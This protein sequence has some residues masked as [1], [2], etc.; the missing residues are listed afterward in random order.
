MTGLIASRKKDK[1]VKA[2][3]KDARGVFYSVGFPR[4]C[5]EEV[6]RGC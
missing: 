6:M 3:F 5:M 4:V 2:K 1:E